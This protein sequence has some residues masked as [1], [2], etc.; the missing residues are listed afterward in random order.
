MKGKIFAVGDNVDTDVIAPTAYFHL[1]SL[2]ALK[3]HCM[4]AVYPE[5]YKK[6]SVGDVLVAGRNFGCGSSR[7][8]AAI[9][10]KEL[11]FGLILARSFARIFFRNAVN[12]ALPVGTVTASGKLRDG[13]I[14]Q[15]SIKDGRLAL[16]NGEMVQF[17][18]V[19]G[20]LKDIFDA[21]GLVEFVRKNGGVSSD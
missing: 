6:V 5:L 16:S 10:L 14:V 7:E 18:R 3:E 9:V 4:E 1:N 21:G 19:E 20:P 12:V 8:Q 15:Y 13:D 17:S 11:G 2:Q